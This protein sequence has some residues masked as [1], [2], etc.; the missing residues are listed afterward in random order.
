MVSALPDPIDSMQ[1][2]FKRT[3]VSFLY[4]KPEELSMIKQPMFS[5]L[6]E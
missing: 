3:E 6:I 2:P 4:S 5:S 1:S